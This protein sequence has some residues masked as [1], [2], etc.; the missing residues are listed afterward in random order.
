MT[1][2]ELMERA[3]AFIALCESEAFRL[4]KG[5]RKKAMKIMQGMISKE[6]A[7][8]LFFGKELK[9]GRTEE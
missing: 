2:K 6:E 8:R 9:N 4:A 3:N 1:D 5:D 7:E